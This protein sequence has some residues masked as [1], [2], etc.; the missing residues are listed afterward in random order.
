MRGN[1]R[2]AR[3]RAPQ[4]FGPRFVR[5]RKG[6]RKPPKPPKAPKKPGGPSIW[7]QIGK[8]GLRCFGRG[9]RMALITLA[10]A[11]SLVVVS[12]LLVAGYLYVSK[13]D[14]FSVKRVTI[15]GISQIT[16]EEVLAVTGL[17]RPVN[18]LTFDP[19]QAGRD[20]STLPW[21][22]E[23]NVSRKM[24]DA[25][26]IEITE[27]RPKLLV[28]LGRLYYLNDRGEPF[29]ELGPGE[30]PRL[31]IVSGFGEDDLLSPGPAVKAAMAE[32]FWLVETLAPRN[33]EFGLDNISEINYDLV[34]GLT[35][36][37]KN[38][39][40]EVKVGFG[41]YEEKFRRL[42]RVLAHLKVRGKYDGLVYL[43]LEASPRVTV[44]YDESPAAPADKG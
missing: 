4:S 27:H 14:Y 38:K 2:Q 9:L 35:V 5:D 19:D 15:S 10:V 34:R 11:A 23:V 20:L 18:I 44:R 7:M 25:V 28:S 17:D 36:Y 39:G 29:K 8:L 12:G 43:N 6:L 22:A 1:D 42:G 30:S 33:D 37:T 26:S 31:P 40:L 24:P 41:A 21:L 13:S 3:N 16:R 32:V